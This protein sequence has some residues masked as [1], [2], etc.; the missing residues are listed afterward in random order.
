[1]RTASP[2]SVHSPGR[3]LPTALCNRRSKNSSFWDDVLR[4]LR[5]YRTPMDEFDAE[6]APLHPLLC[7]QLRLLENRRTDVAN[8]SRPDVAYDEAFLDSLRNDLVGARLVI[9]AALAASPPDVATGAARE[10]L[11]LRWREAGDLLCEV[12]SPH[13]PS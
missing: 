6:Y 3:A 11:Q 8:L 2:S 1:M 10:E 4:Q 5:R 13:L 12:L 9:L 7:E